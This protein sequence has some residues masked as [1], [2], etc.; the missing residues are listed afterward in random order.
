MSFFFLVIVLSVLFRLTDSDYPFELFKLFL[1][2]I[3]TRGDAFWE[4]VY[5]IK[6]VSDM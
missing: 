6:F 3:L 1:V 5:T 2:Y 4:Q